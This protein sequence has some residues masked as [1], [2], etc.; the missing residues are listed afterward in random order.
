[1]NINTTLYVVEHDY[2]RVQAGPDNKKEDKKKQNNNRETR[3]VYTG[4]RRR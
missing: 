3:H 1:M 2:V 4:P